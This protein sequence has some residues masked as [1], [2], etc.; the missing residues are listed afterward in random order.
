MGLPLKKG[1]TDQREASLITKQMEQGVSTVF[2]GYGYILKCALTKGPV[3]ED[4][5]SFVRH[6]LLCDHGPLILQMLKLCLKKKDKFDSFV[7][8]QMHSETLM[9]SEINQTQRVKY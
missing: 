1:S 2:L 9:L 4:G 5:S 8:K 6:G 3:S 7:G